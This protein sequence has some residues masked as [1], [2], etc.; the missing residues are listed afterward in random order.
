MTSCTEPRAR[1]APF[2]LTVLVFTL[3][4]CSGPAPRKSAGSRAPI[5][6][7][8]PAAPAPAAVVANVDLGDPD[9][10]FQEALRLMKARQFPQAQQAFLDLSR[11][12]PSFSG[13]LTDLGILYAQNH[14]HDLALSSLA[15]AV[16]ANPANEVA[17]NW[18]GTLYRENNEPLRAEQSYRS[19]IKA[20]PDYAQAHLNLAILYDVVLHRPA[21]ALTAYREYQRLSGADNLVVAAWIRDIETRLQPKPTTTVAE[22]GP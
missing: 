14:Q 10:R 18:L 12:F 13:P 6:A 11:D 4:A 22:A 17:H 5:V 20:R 7:S 2:A 9:Q 21:E 16:Q 15:R 8:T 1:C 3:A 19:A